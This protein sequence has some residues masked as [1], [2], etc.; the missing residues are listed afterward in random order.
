SKAGELKKTAAREEALKQEYRALL[1]EGGEEGAVPLH[2]GPASLP[3]LPEAERLLQT[4]A[5]GLNKISVR[6][7]EGRRASG[8]IQQ[9]RAERDA[10]RD[11]VSESGREQAVLD[12]RKKALE[13]A[14]A[15]CRAKY[16]NRIRE[17]DAPDVLSALAAL[18]SI[19]AGKEK[20]D[21]AYKKE[22]ENAALALASA[23][24]GSAAAKEARRQAEL[25]HGEGQRAFAEKLAA[26]P[27]PDLQ[28]LEDASLSEDGIAGLEKSLR[29]R[30]EKKA[31]LSGRV[32][33]LEDDLAS[34]G[35]EKEGAT[36]PGTRA[37]TERELAD[38]ENDYREIQSIRDEAAGE[39]AAAGRD[40]KQYAEI[41]ARREE[42]AKETRRYKALSDDLS[43][44]DKKKPAFDVWLLGRYLSEVS[45]YA[46]KRLERM[47]EGRYALILDREGE[48]ARG[49]TGLDLAVFDA[50]TGRSRPCG[51]LS[52]GESFMA[53]IS[54]ALGLAD[55]IQARSGGIRLDAVFIDEGFG[56]LDEASL[57]KALNIL[58]ELR[59]HRM[60][61][62]ISHVG[63]MRSR[64]PSRIE[65]SKTALGSKI[66]IAADTR[67]APRTSREALIYSNA[68][69][70]VLL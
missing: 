69:K 58:D 28:A 19:L 12:A 30:G 50:H 9:A 15:S 26:S 2:Q 16:E 32:K 64:V 54:L 13:E 67:T 43:G 39:L 70:S 41:S 21:A 53:S 55:S 5:A 63:E 52:G 37:E 31:E 40:Q 62:I 59:E 56:S 60:V 1:S 18:D 17:W 33:N 65:V 35:K 66:S 57:D 61:G 14:A 25:R 22:K 38:L 27:F 4:H 49:K 24:T 29:L 36:R 7:E 34:L 20:E 42:L 48:G 68:N 8:Q 51:T 47:S 3:E 23:R 45:A 46:T 10:L 11:E 44:N 6:R